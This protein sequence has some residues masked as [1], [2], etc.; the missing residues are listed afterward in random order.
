MTQ[1]TL[2]NQKHR[3]AKYNQSLAIR[4]ALILMRTIK[5]HMKKINYLITINYLINI[6]TLTINKD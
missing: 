1:N 6:I 5:F 2:T 4:D 3:A